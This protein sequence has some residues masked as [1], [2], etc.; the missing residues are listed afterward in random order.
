[1]K[2]LEVVC[3]I[4][5]RKDDVLAAKRHPGG[6]AG[7]KW[8]FP[9]GK[10]KVNETPEQAIQREIKEEL[11][12]TIKPI[13]RLEINHHTYP[14]FKISLLPIT[15]DITKGEPVAIEHAEIRWIATEKLLDLDWAEADEPIVRQYLSKGR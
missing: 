8:E 15:C 12:V 11:G 5:T 10:I 7:G 2:Q 13:E 9:G 1:V 14:E 3:A 6:P 4:I